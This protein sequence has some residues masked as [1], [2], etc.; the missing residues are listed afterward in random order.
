MA[1]NKSKIALQAELDEANDYIESLEGKLD[2][3]VGIAAGEDEDEPSDMAED[4]EELESR[5]DDIADIATQDESGGGE[6]EK[7]AA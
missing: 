1:R 2:D 5:L 7:L 6:E 3:I 4:V